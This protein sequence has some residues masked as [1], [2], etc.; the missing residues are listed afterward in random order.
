[1]AGFMTSRRCDKYFG[2]QSKWHVGELT[3]PGIEYPYLGSKD[4]VKL[5][6]V[7]YI[8]S[9]FFKSKLFNLCD[10]SDREYYEWVNDRIVNGWFIQYNKQIK[11][12]ESENGVCVHVYLEWGQVYLIAVAKRE[13][14]NVQPSAFHE[15][16][17][18][19]SNII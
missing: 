19:R 8:P 16:W 13:V 17:S 4:S 18:N 7:D 10:E 5:E 12:I 1:M 15:Y 3:W 9:V 6:N 11:P 14:M 2:E